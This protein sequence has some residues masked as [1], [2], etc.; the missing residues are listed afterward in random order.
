MADYAELE[1]IYNNTPSGSREEIDA[2]KALADAYR[3]EYGPADQDYRNW[4]I[5]YWE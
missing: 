3:T 2:I 5:R 4:M 1:R